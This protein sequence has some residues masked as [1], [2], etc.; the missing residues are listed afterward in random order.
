MFSKLSGLWS[1]FRDMGIIP[2]PRSYA[3]FKVV[4]PAEVVSTTAQPEDTGAPRPKL[5]SADQVRIVMIRKMLERAAAEDPAAAESGVPEGGEFAV[6]TQGV[7]TDPTGQSE[8]IRGEVTFR[9]DVPASL[10]GAEAREDLASSFEVHLDAPAGDLPEGGTLKLELEFDR[11]TD[12]DLGS[13][14][15]TRPEGEGQGVRVWSVDAAGG[16]TLAAVGRV[17]QGALYVGPADG[18]RHDVMTLPHPPGLSPLGR[19]VGVE[20]RAVDTAI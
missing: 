7:V 10:A 9:G 1:T 8:I 14:D 18:A 5:S 2:P 16:K 6:H 20:S 12:R 13:V 19:E 17:G 4:T 11:Q 3:G 15:G